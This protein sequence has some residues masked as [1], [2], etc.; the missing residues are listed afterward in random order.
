MRHNI[1]TPPTETEDTG[2]Y[3][4]DIGSDPEYE[5]PEVMRKARESSFFS[6]DIPEP[7]IYEAPPALTRTGESTMA[8]RHE[9]SASEATSSDAEAD[10]IN[11]DIRDLIHHRGQKS[12]DR[13]PPCTLFDAAAGESIRHDS[14][15]LSSAYAYLL[16]RGAWRI[17][18]GVLWHG[19]TEEGL[20]VP[21]L[22]AKHLYALLP[23]SYIIPMDT[24][25]S[26]FHRLSERRDIID[27][28]PFFA[29]PELVSFADS[30]YNTITGEIQNR[31]LGDR[32]SY[33]L[34]VCFA[35]ASA[36]PRLKEFEAV[37]T[38][39][40]GSE[41]TAMLL[42]EFFGLA[43]SAAPAGYLLYIACDNRRWASRL[44]KLLASVFRSVDTRFV[45]LRDHDKA[46]KTS[47][48]I[49]R[50]ILLSLKEG[51][52]IVRD[53]ET[54]LRLVD[55]DGLNADRKFLSSV[56]FIA[57]TSLLCAGRRLPKVRDSS[58]EDA[59]DFIK[60]ARLT[61]AAPCE[62]SSSEF[63]Q[64]RAELVHWALEG[65]QR[66]LANGGF[67]FSD[68]DT[69]DENLAALRHFL[70]E[71]IVAD[72]NASTASSRLAVSYAA[73]CAERGL[74]QVSRSSLEQ[75]VRERF[76]IRATTVRDPFSDRRSTPE[77]GYRGL[78]LL[79]EMIPFSESAALV[80]EIEDR[81]DDDEDG[82]ENDEDVFLPDFEP[83]QLLDDRP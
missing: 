20:W 2:L 34:N 45:S 30:V 49:G 48:C 29:R 40:A 17:V 69:V 80:A 39:L 50:H 15:V 76:G 77:S 24:I 8:T 44:L 52:A 56:D 4:I 68:G 73:Y 81:L 7:V 58:I 13:T 65:L 21:I 28:E 67:T 32:L 75:A 26:I 54:V 18:N 10:D 27:D 19:T 83:T 74:P 1:S 41:D 46:F 71:V 9:L 12:Q 82:E 78:R 47:D 72:P 14:S 79:S 70:E 63:L 16:R 33:A 6:I 51:E 23:D 42:Q 31:T 55:G 3:T 62:I 43:I 59:A 64:W 5:E 22:E 66:Y 11:E 36:A 53:L 37:V 35:Q 57:A 61:G 25:S 60:I 38:A